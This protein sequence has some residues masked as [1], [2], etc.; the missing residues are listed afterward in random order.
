MSVHQ[1]LVKFVKA[2][3]QNRYFKFISSVRLAVPLMLVLCVLVAYGTVVESN[4]NAEYA[5]MAIYKTDWFGAFLI[6]LW[7]NIFTAMLSRYPYKLHQTGFGCQR[8]PTRC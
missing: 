1:L 7:I 4:Y 2:L 5:S 6:L 3:N 8:A